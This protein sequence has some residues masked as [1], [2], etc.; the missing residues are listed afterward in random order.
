M[1]I[2]GEVVEDK[3][4]VIGEGEGMTMMTQEEMRGGA[5]VT[6]GDRM[7]NNLIDAGKAILLMI[8]G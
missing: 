1:M 2:P 8:P 7:E 4:E 6:S 3:A 5:E